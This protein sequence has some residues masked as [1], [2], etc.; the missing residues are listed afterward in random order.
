MDST[1]ETTDQS[2]EADTT[3]TINEQP[4][5][6]SYNG[7]TNYETWLLKLNLDNDYGLYQ[8]CNEYFEES[9]DIGK[10]ELSQMFKEY[11]E[12]LFFIEEHNIIKLCDTWTWRDWEDI[13]FFEIVG[14]YLE[15]Y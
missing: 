13:N 2:N 7:W 11:L 12:E 5:N 3:Q 1:H 15:D 10:Y 8:M 14:S 9:K 4:I 6:K